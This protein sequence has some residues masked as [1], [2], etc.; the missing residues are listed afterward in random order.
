[1]NESKTVKI[2]LKKLIED[3]IFGYADKDEDSLEIL[4][5]DFERTYNAQA[6]DIKKA[7]IKFII[8]NVYVK[9]NKKMFKYFNTFSK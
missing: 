9:E 1:M 6:E 5:R 7:I 4:K 8:N 3:F 2:N